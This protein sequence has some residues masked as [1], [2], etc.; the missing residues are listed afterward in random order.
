LEELRWVRIRPGRKT[1]AS[2]DF[3]EI[4]PD[5]RGVRPRPQRFVIENLLRA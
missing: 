4:L 1:A 3:P 2:G 5:Y